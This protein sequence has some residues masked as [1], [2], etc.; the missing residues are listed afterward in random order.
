[1][2]P[3]TSRNVCF[4]RLCLLDQRA[5][6]SIGLKITDYPSDINEIKRSVVFDTLKILANAG[7]IETPKG[8]WDI[9]DFVDTQVAKLV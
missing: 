4:Y 5:N 6:V 7:V 8:G 1:M 3:R 2:K 9:E